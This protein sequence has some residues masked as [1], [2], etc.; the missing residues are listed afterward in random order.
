MTVARTS[1]LKQHER[2]H[3]RHAKKEIQELQEVKAEL[4]LEIIET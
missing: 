2:I 1:N 4:E 3:K